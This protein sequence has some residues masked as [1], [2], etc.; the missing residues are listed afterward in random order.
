[1]LAP[2]F[3]LSFPQESGAADFAGVPF[4]DLAARSELQTVVDREPGQYLGHPTTALLG[5]GKTIVC[6]YPKGHGKGAIVLKRSEDGGRTWSERMP[7]PENWATSQETPTIHRVRRADGGERLILF[8]GLNP[9]RTARSEDGGRTWTPLAPTG[10]W[11]GIVAMA[12]VAE[13]RDGALLAWF[14]DDGRFI[15]NPAY[16]PDDGARFH[17][18]QTRS[19]DGGLSWSAPRAIASHPQAHLCEPGFVRSP[20]GGTIALLLR[21]NSRKFHSFIIFSRDEGATW[22][23]PR[24]TTLALTGDRHVARYAPDGR[25]L[26]TFRDTA[27]GSPTAGDWCA[28]LGR[29]EDLAAGTPGALRIRLMDNLHQ[30]DC[31]Y[32]GLELLPD[33]TFVATTYGH[34]IEGQPPFIVSLRLGA[35]DLAR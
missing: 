29:W 34:W 32:P 26:V 27:P 24:E 22:S 12:S 7:T 16:V 5:D 23:E 20:D 8:S 2:L 30:W 11:G 4:L 15:G 10:D 14:H 35:E 33:G 9:V 28:W 13:T 1:M 17:V 18:F 31:A 3:L 21:E 25:L 6:V 19:E